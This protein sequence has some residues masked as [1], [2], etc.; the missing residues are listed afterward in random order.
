[1][2][3]NYRAR[4][5][6]YVLA[7]VLVAVAESGG[8]RGVLFWLVLGT[9]AAVWPHAALLIARRS[10][11]PRAA[12][13]RSVT[14]DAAAAGVIS[15]LLAFPLWPTVVILLPPFM[16]NLRAGGVPRAAVALLASAAA[17]AVTSAALGFP[18]RP[19][20]NAVTTAVSILFLLAYMSYFALVTRSQGEAARRRG[21]AL[22]DTLQR[23]TATSEVLRTIGSSRTNVKAVFDTIVRSSVELCDASMGAAFQF[24]GE[25]IHLV[26]HHHDN[27]AEAVA[28]MRSA[29]PMRPTRESLIA[30]VVMDRAV[31]HVPDIDADPSSP[32]VA[33]ARA[34]GI[35]SFLGVPM[36]R[37]GEPIGVIAVG[38]ETPEPF[39]DA[40]VDLLRTFADQAVIAVDNARL[41]GALEARTEEVAAVLAETRALGEVMQA[42][43]ASLDLRQ[44][45][46][47]VIRHAV[48][49]TRSDA[50]AIF[51][52]TPATGSFVAVAAHKMGRQFLDRIAVTP[53]DPTQGAIAR[54]IQDV[55]PW[56]IADVEAAHRYVF[57]DLTLAEG[58]RALMA[59]PIPSTDVIRGIT[60]FRVIA[61]RFDERVAELLL[62]LST[63][64]KIA[65][66]NATLFQ[67]TQNQG[68]ELERLSA[69]MQELYRLS[70]AMQEPLTLR[71]QLQRVLEAATRRG[72][73]ERVFVWAVSD[74]GERLVNLAGAG[75]SQ[76]EWREF[77]GAEIP[78]AEAG[79]MAKAFRE[80]TSLLFT[81]DHP[82]PPE[83]R[84]K[85][86]HS[87]LRGVRT[88][89]FFIIPM[90]ARGQT[91]GIFTGDNKPSRRPISAGTL[92]LLQT[93][94]SHA[95]VAVANARL[96]QEIA[97]QSR[98][99]EI[100]SRHKS[101]F[102]SNMSHELRTPLNA[103]IGFAEVLTEHMFGELN[104]KQEEYLRDITESGRHLLS[105]INDILDLAKV[106][107]GRME[108]EPSDVDVP[109]LIDNALILVRERAA[110]RGITVAHTV[111]ARIVTV[112]GDERKLKQI[113]LNLLS[114]AIK[115]TPAGGRIDVTATLGDGAVAV[116]VRDTGVGITPEEHEAVFEEFRQVGSNTAKHEGTGLGLA[117]CRKFVELHG[118]RIWVESKVGEGSAFT[119]TLPLPEGTDVQSMGTSSKG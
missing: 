6:V 97:E 53:V 8:P 74:D 18:L 15:A 17:A 83:L 85:P 64:S 21:R 54:S 105:L 65:V 82:L 79:A 41:F 4:L 90:V 52:Y 75:F 60:V 69:E 56:Q 76:E 43:G 99:L 23:Q 114:N 3:I 92:D 34:V 9:F 93:F 37:D 47:T 2:A 44:V 100:A 5:G 7:L 13:Q 73:I 49:L 22:A 68:A 115:F 102:L 110:G 26:A 28:A 61:G 78:L 113:L 16:S 77:E 38:R 1:M 50:G 31:V 66:D 39:T 30:R 119:F 103:I 87:N 117:L 108:L 24:D 104:A 84:L 88:Q 118:G 112:R 107:A 27:T 80:G 42:I 55:K 98:Q 81:R 96:F 36:L 25:W 29:F 48:Q 12:E 32:L 51:E 70:T 62:A 63:Q 101:E 58:Y 94:A 86:P 57:R 35:R 106:E 72:I 59:V 91:V 11:D 116:A 67:T 111:D 10:R 14:V 45:L 95:A 109:R 40:Q 89:E 19:D 33:V 46:D 71:E 20:S